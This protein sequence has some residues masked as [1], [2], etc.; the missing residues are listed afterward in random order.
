MAL[1]Y[2][3]IFMPCHDSLCIYTVY[4][5]ISS[6]NLIINAWTGQQ[7]H[8]SQYFFFWTYTLISVLQLY[9]KDDNWDFLKNL[10]VLIFS[11]IIISN[12]NLKD[13][14]YDDKYSNKYYTIIISGTSIFLMFCSISNNIQNIWWYIIL[15]HGNI[16]Y[17]M[18]CPVLVK[19]VVIL[20][21]FLV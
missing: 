6:P 12:M 2:H 3:Y 20:V 16:I 7:H 9:C 15:Y 5:N 13:R 4:L 19:N 10:I 14:V 17:H 18:Y 21:T 11:L 8:R 1:K